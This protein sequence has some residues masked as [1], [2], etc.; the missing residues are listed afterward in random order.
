MKKLIN[1]PKDMVRD[2]LEG[3]E[4]AHADLI[5]VLYE[6]NYVVRADRAVNGKVAIISGGGSGHEPMHAGFVGTGMLDAACP[7]AVFTPPS[8]EQIFAA[9]MAADCGAGVL[10]VVKNYTGDVS[11]FTRAAIKAQERDIEV[12][13]VVTKDD[14]VIKE[15]TNQAEHCGA[16]VTVLAEKMAGAAA[17]QMLPL[18]A[19]AEVCQKVNDS[20][21]SMQMTLASC[22][23]PRTGK[24]RLILAEKEM[25]RGTSIHA[26]RGCERME[27]RCA[28]EVTAILANPILDELSLR[29]G[30]AV[31][32]LVNGMGGTPL[33]ELYVVFKEL[34]KICSRRGIRII[35]NLVG[36]Y[37]TSL[38][39][40]GCSITLVKM[41][42]ELTRL[43]DAP[44]RTPALRWGM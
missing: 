43:W 25:E 39:M 18:K 14:L 29:N 35:R 30:D 17:E 21:R 19:V 2:A 40:A 27:F 10:Y 26:E 37:I 22:I 7:G 32:A 4:A 34:V 24:P 31:L 15:G 36:A 9:T 6:P 8:S 1:D 20:G 12:A 23:D 16:G 13:S 41:D 28:A 5:R 33:G 44:V 38:E 42:D 3:M 11:N